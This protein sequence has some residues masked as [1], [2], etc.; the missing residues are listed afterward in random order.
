MGLKKLLKLMSLD[1][2][3]TFYYGRHSWAT[4]ARNICK[5]S[6]EDIGESL[7]HASSHDVTDIYIER[8]WSII[9]ETNRKVLD[10]LLK[11]EEPSL[12]FE[13]EIHEDDLMD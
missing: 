12:Q 1:I 11:P 10:V 9:D 8:D 7:N 5:V 13:Y 2:E 3:L 4:I 6:K